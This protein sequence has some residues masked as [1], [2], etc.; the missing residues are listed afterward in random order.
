MSTNYLMEYPESAL[1][2]LGKRQGALNAEGD[3]TKDLDER[4]VASEYEE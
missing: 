1:V 4:I 3:E 2:E